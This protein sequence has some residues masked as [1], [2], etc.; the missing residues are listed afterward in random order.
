MSMEIVITVN[1]GHVRKFTATNKGKVNPEDGLGVLEGDHT[2]SWT[3]DDN[4][5]GNLVH[6]RARGIE[7]LAAAVIEAH[8]PHAEARMARRNGR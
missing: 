7:S 3:A 1:G 6:D 5:G 2:Y 8:R 4:T